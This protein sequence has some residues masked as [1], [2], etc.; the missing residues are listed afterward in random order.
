MGLFLQGIS[1]EEL[2]ETIKGIVAEE[3]K[4][5]LTAISETIPKDTTPEYLSRKETA[6]MLG[7][8]LPTL[9]SYVKKGYLTAHRVGEKTIRF[10]KEDVANA[11]NAVQPMKYRRA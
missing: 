7:V 9:H 4:N 8:S 3:V 1:V 5:A 2:S 11:L 10:R 6:E